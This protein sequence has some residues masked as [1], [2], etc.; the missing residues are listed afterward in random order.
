MK[1]IIFNEYMQNIDLGFDEIWNYIT[2]G[3]KENHYDCNILKNVM[4][5]LILTNI[6][7]YTPPKRLKI[8]KLKL[9][10]EYKVLKIFTTLIFL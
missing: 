8:V 2:K 5:Y 6:F 9:A 1:V 10:F 7:K 4:W 3:V